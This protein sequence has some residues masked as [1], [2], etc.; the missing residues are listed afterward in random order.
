VSQV[1]GIDVVVQGHD[2][3]LYDAPVWLDALATAVP[4]ERRRQLLHVGR[5]RLSY[6]PGVGVTVDGWDAL[7][8]DETTPAR[9]TPSPRSS[10]RPRPG[11]VQK[12]GDVYQTIVGFAPGT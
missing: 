2:H 9:P 11:S 1:G 8:V 10:T 5:L 6:T 4:R 12:Y 3:A 7:P